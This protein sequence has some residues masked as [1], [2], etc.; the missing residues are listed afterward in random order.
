MDINFHENAFQREQNNYTL[1]NY[2]L[3]SPTFLPSSFNEWDRTNDLN[4][5]SPSTFFQNSITLPTPSPFDS[6]IGQ[7]RMTPSNMYFNPI[8]SS[9][10]ITHPAPAPSPFITLTLPSSPFVTNPAPASSSPFM[11]L[12]L[13]LS[14]YVPQNRDPTTSLSTPRT[15]MFD[16]DVISPRELQSPQSLGRLALGVNMI[17]RF[18]ETI[19]ARTAP[20]T[21]SPS[22]P[23]PRPVSQRPPTNVSPAPSPSVSSTLSRASQ[24]APTN[25]SP[26]S[27]SAP[28]T[29]LQIPPTNTPPVSPSTK[30]KRSDYYKLKVVNMYGEIDSTYLKN[31]N[32]MFAHGQDHKKMK[33]KIKTL[34]KQI[35]KLKGNAEKRAE[36]E[37]K[38]RNWKIC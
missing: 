19:S 30:N 8:R 21:P 16:S 6:T 24:S 35:K 36:F 9:P 31:Y 12:T 1:L 33:T 38:V 34:R 27:P 2:F 10:F 14:P 26:V 32:E 22:M 13:P 15:V 25:T 5:I 17:E 3:H 20:S 11:T 37:E 4:G 28:S 29:P 18:N 23:P 7:Y